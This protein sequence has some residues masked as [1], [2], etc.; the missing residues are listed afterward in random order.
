MFK[1]PQNC[2]H[3]TY[4]QSNVEV[5]RRLMICFPLLLLQTPLGSKADL[6]H[7]PSP[8]ATF[9]IEDFSPAA[10]NLELFPCPICHFQSTYK[11]YLASFQKKCLQVHPHFSHPFLSLSLNLYPSCLDFCSVPQLPSLNPI[12]CLQSIFY[13]LLNIIFKNVKQ[14]RLSYISYMFSITLRIQSKNIIQKSKSP[15]IFPSFLPLQCQFLTV[16]FLSHSECNSFL[17]LPWTG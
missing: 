15:C 6:Q 11:S 16:S 10:S 2:T 9:S 13:T 17:F 7:R 4:Q 12:I 8:V 1:L 14:I 5:S 3:L